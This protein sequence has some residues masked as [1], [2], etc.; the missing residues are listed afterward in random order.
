[1]NLTN[2]SYIPEYTD[3]TKAE[4]ALK[5]H[6][7]LFGHT[8]YNYNPSGSQIH[9]YYHPISKKE[10]PRDITWYRLPDFG[11]YGDIKLVWEPSRFTHVYF[12]IHAYAITKDKKFAEGCLKQIQNWCEQNPFPYGVHYKDGQEISFRL[13][14]W[15]AA[16]SFFRDFLTDSFKNTILSA[17]Y[18]ALRRIELN[19]AFA[20]NSTRNNHSLSEA[21][22]LVI[23][24]LLFPHF[25]E[26]QRF[27][28]KGLYYL[29]RELGYQVYPDG[30]YIQH[31]MTY[32]RLALDIL[33]FLI[34]IAKR[35][36]ISLPFIVEESHRKMF[37]F[38][39]AFT[40]NN[41][42]VPNY[43]SNDSAILF[44]VSNIAYRDFRPSLNFA[45][46]LIEGNPLYQEGLDS[47]KLFG[48]ESKNT[49][50]N[51]FKSQPLS[52]RHFPDGGYYI[53]KHQG[54]F[55]FIRC[56]SYKDRPSQN[57]MLHLD[58]W[59]K[60]KNLLCDTGSYS[61]NTDP[62]I[63]DQF[64]G[65][66]GHNTVRIGKVNY[67]D[68]ALHFGLT[69]WVTSRMIHFSD[70]FFSGEHNGYVKKFGIIHRRSLKFMPNKLIVQDSLFGITKP[71][72][73]EQFWITPYLPHLLGKN[74]YQI[75]NIQI[76]TDYSSRIESA[77]ISDHYHSFK[78]AKKITVET[79]SA[80]DICLTTAILLPS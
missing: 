31:S 69:D 3:I 7:Y 38:L 53:L 42:Y 33:S 34:L 60:D 50:V 61:Y 74:H 46:V 45:S 10:T 64:I 9:W 27:F 79:L 37:H 52:T 44:P 59:Y 22:A 73:I 11:G 57:D 18:T 62:E 66:Q 40:R 51:T 43:G 36:N 65:V 17:I 39:L 68:P 56:H 48:G 80:R 16:C 35:M 58:L 67:M 2:S 70:T 26:H 21:A 12:L 41:G 20:A 77:K 24:G 28:K 23:G 55:L 72:Q 5:G 49:R 78:D 6:F 54:L 71:V 14:S 30:S 32:H 75:E 15:L 4:E 8:F 1:M 63:K 76:K 19:I 25:K 29:T 13:F 47:I